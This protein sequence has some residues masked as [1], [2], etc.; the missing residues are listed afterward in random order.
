MPANGRRGAFKTVEFQDRTF[1]PHEIR[2]ITRRQNTD[3]L[4]VSALK[5]SIAVSVDIPV[6]NDWRFCIQRLRETANCD[7]GK[8]RN[9]NWK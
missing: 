1:A 3:L 5:S 9:C 8:E 6:E 4:V 7:Y 2:G